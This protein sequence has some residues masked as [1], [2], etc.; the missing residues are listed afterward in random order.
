M[1]LELAKAERALTEA[2]TDYTAANAQAQQAAD[3]LADVESRK[4][5]IT[6][7][8]LA[9]TANDR[10]ASEFVALGADAEL[11][12]KMLDVARQVEAQAR[13]K[14]TQAAHVVDRAKATH[15]RAQAVVRYEA[16]KTQCLAVEKV[17]IQAILKTYQAAQA[18]GI[19][20]LS[21]AYPKSTA[22]RYI[23][24]LNAPPPEH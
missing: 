20:T 3:R 23:F 9:G 18:V 16:L 11:L 5:A 15:E 6:Q 24:D 10:D 1:S 21:G 17:F 4:S 14:V 19:S 12:Q 7:R 22:I 13:D 2:T 8:R